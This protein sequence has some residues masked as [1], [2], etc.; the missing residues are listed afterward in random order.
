MKNVLLGTM[1][2]LALVCC[3]QAATILVEAEGFDDRGGWVVDQ[4]S[5]GVMG[6]PYLLAHGL[7]VP[8]ADAKTTVALPEPGT[9]RV[10]VRTKDWVARW[11]ARGAPG[12]FQL[13]IDGNSLKETF[14]TKGVE[15][16]W[17]DGGT[18]EIGKK[19]ITL[20]LHDLTGFEGRC[21]A[22]L[23]TNEP[24]F[25]PPNDLDA[26]AAFRKEML[27]LPKRPH[28]AGQFDM[29]VVG[30]GVA[31]CCTAVSA[32]RLGVKV[33]LIQD[34]PVLGGNSSSEVR[35]GISGKINQPPY[36][37]LGEIVAEMHAVGT[38]R[39]RNAGL[40]NDFRD[41]VKL[42]MV[43][44]EENISLFLCEHVCKVEMHNG[45]VTAVVSKNIVT[46]RESRFQGRWFADCT[47]D[48]TVGF[49][50]GA[51]YEVTTKGHM[52]SSNLWSVRDAGVPSGFPRCPWGLDLADKPIP[53][54]LHRLGEWF[55][56]SGFDL[57]TIKDAEA[58]R[59]HNLRAIYSVW[60]CLKNVKKLY[61]N[62][63]L[64]WVA[65]ISGR[66]ESRRLWGDVI[67]TVEDIVRGKQYED[68]CVT[69]T[70]PV[71]LHYPDPKYAAAS[72]GNE[73]ISIAK[74]DF[75]KAPYPVPYRCLYSRNVAN[76][77]MAGRDISVTHEALGT[78]RVMATTGMMGEVLGR[79]AFLCKKHGVDPRGVYEKYLDE[80]KQL[81]NQSIK[82]K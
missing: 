41:G 49:L 25:I 74:C 51:D 6:S 40:A 32:A 50:A 2:S 80:F 75:K 24:G 81:L 54:K 16:F 52:G 20:A 35:V 70:W 36:P 21:D 64:Q 19:K 7:G 27:A 65:Y 53:T 31:G 44:A 10:F 71:D 34:R 47:G 33:A 12:K 57:D 56:E 69:A 62:H 1:L 60:D 26:L 58:I 5:M 17:H 15:W 45:R 68:G 30:G 59:D 11:N 63:E 18:V 43:K 38:E 42:N 9:Y 76:L 77:M 8:V 72:P 28:D 61:P 78:V 55:W 22:I 29:V 48:G 46:G 13:L 66:R 39:P 4:Q 67:L 14:G 3:T 79:A 73:F 82:K 23:L 37:I